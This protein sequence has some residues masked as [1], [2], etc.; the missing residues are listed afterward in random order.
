MLPQGT[1]RYLLNEKP[2]YLIDTLQPKNKM[3]A[4][5]ALAS[6]LFLALTLFHAPAF[7]D[8]ADE[9]KV[10]IEQNRAKEA[11]ELG[12]KHQNLLG[13]ERFDYVFGVAA[14]DYGRVS[15]GVLSL[16]RV[17]LANPGDDLVRLE[18]ARGYYNLGEY[19]RAKDE[20]EEVLSHKPP[21]GVANTINTYLDLIKAQE[22]K[23]R[24]NGTLFAEYGLGYNSNANAATAVNN[25]ILPIFG[26]VQLADSAKAQPSNFSYMSAGASVNVPLASGITSFSSVSTSVQKYAQVDGYDLNVTNALTG[27]KFDDDVNI[28]KVAGFGTIA[29]IDQM[30]VPDTLGGGVQ[31]ERI[32]TPQ[33]AVTVSAS[34]SQLIY[35][36]Q[37]NIYNSNLSTASVGYRWGFPT[38][39]WAP[40]LIA[41]ANFAFQDN[42][43]NRPDLTRRIG[44]ASLTLYALPGE[45]WGLNI[46]AGYAR[47]NYD[48]QDLLYQSYRSDNLT[49]LSAMLEYKLTKSWSTR[50]E[51]TYFNNQS[52][53]S[54]YSYQQATG[55]LKLR[56]A[57]DF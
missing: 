45:K 36:T 53:L 32:L 15:L 14:I 25:I 34:A 50:L 54:L 37:F 2:M 24:V 30:P 43:Q 12:L 7:A 16:E 20:F 49:S 28:V 41:N 44:G 9:M 8:V 46:G 3:T 13:N 42:T 26:P 19:P 5:K 38:T 23:S 4:P 22:K 57:F 56:Y 21:A 31:Y 1:A 35:P 52:N 11:Y 29:Q 47:S 51:A 55:A 33:H 40:V 17:L 18:L 39:A 48:G 27:V 10:L 6:I